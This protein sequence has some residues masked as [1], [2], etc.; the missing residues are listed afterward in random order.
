MEMRALKRKLRIEYEDEKRQNEEEE[1][2]K[3]D[4]GVDNEEA[5][6]N[7]GSENSESKMQRVTS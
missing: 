1:Q 2:T 3:R 4:N 7:S 5:I 6:D